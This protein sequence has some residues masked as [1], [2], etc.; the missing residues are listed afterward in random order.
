MQLCIMLLLLNN[1]RLHISSSPLSAVLGV[2]KAMDTCTVDAVIG[3]MP[4]TFNNAPTNT[5]GLLG[6][7]LNT[8]YA[9]PY[10]GNVTAW[11]F[12]YYISVTQTNTTTIWA[13]VWRESGGYYTL[14]DDSLIGLPIPN[15]QLGFQFVCRY[16]ALNESEAFEV[17][18]GDIVGMYVDG[19][20]DNN[21]VH[22]LGMPANNEPNAGIIKSMDIVDIDNVSNSI[23]TPANYTLY[24]VAILGRITIVCDCNS[25]YCI[26][27]LPTFCC[28]GGRNETRATCSPITTMS[29]TLSTTTA[30]TT[31]PTSTSYLPEEA[32]IA[33]CFL[34]G[35]IV[36]LTIPLIIIVVVVICRLCRLNR[37]VTAGAG[38]LLVC[39]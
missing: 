15:P 27:S 6:L 16:W 29:S 25:Y 24:L 7:F 38:T 33:I 8:N 22:I 13:G 14:V 30:P 31:A 18:E 4:T 9:S 21:V 1:I 17:Q 11:D 35:I 23:L 10:D 26:T 12:C 34:G 5:S 20:E 32:V 28:L 37:Y 19:T 36:A 3:K 2:A 39:S